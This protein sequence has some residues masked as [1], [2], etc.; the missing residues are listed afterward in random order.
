MRRRQLLGHE[1]LLELSRTV[2]W[3]WPGLF[4]RLHRQGTAAQSHPAWQPGALG[5]DV[6]EYEQRPADLRAR[7]DAVSER[8]GLQPVDAADLRAAG[9]R[10]YARPD[11]RNAVDAPGPPLQRPDHRRQRGR[12]GG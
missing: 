3:L 10:A 8:R 12:A 2:Q 1:Q 4:A 5:D 6:A 11:A 7:P 9:G